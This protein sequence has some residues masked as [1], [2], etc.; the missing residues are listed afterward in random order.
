ML[1]GMEQ[2][3]ADRIDAY[4]RLL[5]EVVAIKGHNDPA[6]D[7]VKAGHHEVAHIGGEPGF[8]L[9][10]AEPLDL[11][12]TGGEEPVFVCF[13]TRDTPYQALAARLEASLHRFGL[14]HR[15]VGIDP[16]GSWERNCAMKA[17]FVRDQ[18]RELGRP[19]VWLDADATVEADPVTLRRCGA[20]F[21]IAKTHGW[22]FGSGTVFFGATEA[23][24]RLLDRW[25]LRCEADPLLWDQMHLDAAWADVASTEPLITQWL[26]QSYLFIFDHPP[27]RPPVI[28][29]WQ[30]SRDHKATVSGGTARPKPFIPP[31]LQE[32]RRF[33]R[34]HRSPEA[35]FWGVEGTEHIKPEV[36]V[37]HPEGFDVPATMHALAEQGLPLLEIGCGVGRIAAG[38]AAEEYIGVDVNPHALIAARHAL[39]DHDFRL[40][41]EELAYPRAGTALFYTVL[42]HVPDEALGETLE[43][44][45]AAADRIIIAELM[46]RRWRREGNPPVFNRETEE[47]VLAM[48]SLGF[49]LTAHARVPYAHYDTEQWWA[50]RDTRLAIL[51]F[52]RG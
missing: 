39:P 40:I 9:G 45:A 46:D 18:W 22:E 25:V 24:G 30:A 16:L 47:Y 37:Q 6:Y 49:G 2:F 19:V 14:D 13:Y 50:R 35:L 33:S 21:A 12:D 5:G 27:E 52:E 44:A 7:S 8:W 38:F 1:T 42:L 26:P 31:A 36:G 48:Q 11:V 20:D 28:T 34:F 17:R 23:A 4:A 32:A 41:T 3:A 10:S 15:I 29:H 51:L 43:K